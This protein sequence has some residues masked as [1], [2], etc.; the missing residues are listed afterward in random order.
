MAP[1]LRMRPAQCARS[2]MPSCKAFSPK[3]ADGGLEFVK[4]MCRE[5]K[6]PVQPARRWRRAI[7]RG[8]DQSSPASDRA[9]GVWEEVVDAMGRIKADCRRAVFGRKVLALRARARYLGVAKKMRDKLAQ[10]LPDGPD[11]ANQWIQTQ[12]EGNWP[13]PLSRKGFVV[14]PGNEKAVLVQG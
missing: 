8:E 5:S 2:S 1:Q 11:P 4:T 6:S 14:K 3:A 13:F 12:F 10:L 9:A 7:S